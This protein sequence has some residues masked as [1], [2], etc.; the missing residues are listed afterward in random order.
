MHWQF[1]ISLVIGLN[2]IPG[3]AV[4]TCYIWHKS[5]K[6]VLYSITSVQ[7]IY[8]STNQ[9]T[10]QLLL[11]VTSCQYYFQLSSSSL[12]MLSVPGVVPN[13]GQ[14]V[15]RRSSLLLLI[16]T[17]GGKASCWRNGGKCFSGS[18]KLIEWFTTPWPLKT[19]IL[20]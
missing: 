11:W 2:P 15:I 13:W 19:G 17:F 4:C 1:S 12:N 16:Q 3:Y 8:T 7:D 5:Y 18:K 14:Y 9:C 10:S 6:L 20:N